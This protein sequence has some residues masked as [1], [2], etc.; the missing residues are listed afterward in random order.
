MRAGL[1][2]HPRAR[3]RVT[4]GSEGRWRVRF[5][6]PG[7]RVAVAEVVVEDR[8]GRVRERWT[9]I[10]AEWSMARGIPGAFG[11]VAGALW[12][13]LPLCALFLA[14]FARPPLRLCTSTSSSC[15][16]SA[17]RGPRSRAGTSSSPCRSPIRRSSTSS[18]RLLHV[19]RRG[20]G[21]PPRTWGS[22]T[23]LG[24]GAAFL[25]GV[26]GGLA[27]AGGNVIDVGYAS[28]VGAD[29]LLTGPGLYGAFP[30]DIARGDTYGPVLYALY[31]PFELAWPWS[32]ELG[33]RARGA[34]GGA[35]LG[36]RLRRRPVA[37]GPAAGR[38]APRRAAGVG[39]GDVPV[40]ADRRAR[41]APTTRSWARSSWPRC[42][43]W[44]VPR[45]AA[46]SARSRA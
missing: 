14:P 17:S 40:H 9:G 43:R 25:L 44:A 8:S 45:R 12:V 33:R 20:P 23:L 2:E 16:P 18:L 5:V 46:R 10:Q 13:W 15:S 37:A 42:S 32:G 41:A 28:V 38:P 27:I 24:V 35:R 7:E 22:A 30:L 39:V 21:P 19:A 1:A 34:R 11:G 31:V 3:P 36:R 4:L 29:R 6:E 26:R